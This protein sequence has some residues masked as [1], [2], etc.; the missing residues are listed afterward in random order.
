MTDITFDYFRCDDRLELFGKDKI[1]QKWNVLYEEMD[2]FL[3]QNDLS[4]AATIDKFLLSKAI[5]DFYA[6]IKRLKDFHKIKEVN[7]QKAIAYTAFWLLRRK[8]IQVYNAQAKIDDLSVFKVLPT[9]NERFV[10]QYILNYL[11]V[12]E[13]KSHILAR[14]EEGLKV[15]S[16][17]LLYYLEYRLRDA[18]SLEMILMSFFAGQ[19]YEQTDEDISSKLHPY[20][21]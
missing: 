18:Q 11:S 21:H 17:M 2:F 3:R 16:G 4:S 19:V 14:D 7:S 10:L 15:F 20:D 12:R 9:L 5:L 1:E 13:K 8:P 6:D